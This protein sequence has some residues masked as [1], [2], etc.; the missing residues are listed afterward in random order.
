MLLRLALEASPSYIRSIG[1]TKHQT[2]TGSPLKFN[3]EWLDRAQQ[4]TAANLARQASVSQPQGGQTATPHNAQAASQQA[5]AA[6]NKVFQELISSTSLS[7]PSPAMFPRS[8]GPNLQLSLAIALCR[9]YFE[10]RLDLA[11]EHDLV[12]IAVRVLGFSEVEIRTCLNGEEWARLVEVLSIEASHR[13]R[14]TDQGKKAPVTPLPTLIFQDK[15]V[16]Q[17]WPK[18]DSLLTIFD[19]L[20]EGRKP[21]PPRP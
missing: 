5:P 2:H 1:L 18:V 16:H 10:G 14:I 4:T 13:L 17:G 8:R 9:G 20:R 3:K 11:S 21:Q 12:D 7:M 15:F 6:T 19:D